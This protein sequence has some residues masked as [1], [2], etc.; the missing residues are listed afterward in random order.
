MILGFVAAA[1]LMH[2]YDAHGCTDV[3]GFGIL[4]HASNLAKIQRKEVS[5]VIHNLPIIKN[6]AAVTKVMDDDNLFNLL[7]GKSAETSGQATG[8]DNPS[9]FLY[10]FNC[11][12]TPIIAWSHIIVG[13]LLII[14]PRTAATAYC[15]DLEKEDGVQ[16]WVVGRVEKG[17]RTARII[18]NPRIIEV[19]AKDTEDQIW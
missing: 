11:L 17:D 10:T 16:S 18:D 2:K 15:K 8:A 9:S 13:G 5:F 1:K 3:T 4:G 12:S 19:P 7:K 14:L 6:M